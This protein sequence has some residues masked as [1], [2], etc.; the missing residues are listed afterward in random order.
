[1]IQYKE[2]FTS[3]YNDW[4]QIDI[5]VSRDCTLRCTYCYLHKHKDNKYD[6]EEILTSF[7]KLLNYLHNHNPDGSDKPEGIV[8]GFYPEPWVDIQKTNSLILDTLEIISKYE[9]FSQNY[10]IMLGTNGVRLHEKIPIL[11]HIMNNLSVN[12]TIDGVKEQHDL[13][14][15]FPSGEGS[16]D[17][18]VKNVKQYQ[19]KYNIFST[20][21]TIGPDTIK[22]IYDACLFLWNELNLYDININVVF[23]DLW[24]DNESK[25]RCLKEFDDQLSKIYN[26]IVENKLWEEGKYMGM[27]G[28]RNVPE[29]EKIFIEN[30]FSYI[31]SEWLLTSRAQSYCGA[32][33]MRS[34]DVD[35]GV[36]PCFRLSPYSL[37]FESPFRME[38]GNFHGESMRA[39]HILNTYDAARSKCLECPILSACPMCVGGPM[40]EV[41]SIYDRT[42]HHCEFQKLQYKWSK[43]L[44]LKMNNF[45]VKEKGLYE[46]I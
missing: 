5:V 10:M 46:I 40:E 2:H 14:R 16:W 17:T 45:E 21:V 30:N 7:D 32:A 36:Y 42:T 13:Y 6:R 28:S 9:R 41:K 4:Q 43:K 8:I 35:G 3:L 37:N 26:Y 15:V 20:K 19:D 34:I 39:L 24:G 18:V 23:E 31:E 38:G 29:D 12:V 11:D 33:H 25:E 22:Y 1:M 27:L 44:L